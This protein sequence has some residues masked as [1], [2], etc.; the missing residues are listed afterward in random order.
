MK[1][2]GWLGS[3]GV[4]VLLACLAGGAVL[5]WDQTA[6]TK[7][8]V[9]RVAQAV[10]KALAARD[11]EEH[12]IQLPE[13]GGQFYLTVLTHENYQTRARDRELVA[14]FDSDPHLR[15]LKSQTQFNH[16]TPNQQIYATRLGGAV[17]V[18]EF[19]AV[20]LQESNGRVFFKAGARKLP[21]TPKELVKLIKD[22]C[23]RPKPPGP[24]PSPT[25]GPEPMPFIP[26]VGP[27]DEAP[28]GPAD[29]GSIAWLAALA[30]LLGGGLGVVNEHK[31][32]HGG[33]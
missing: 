26:D 3:I 23:P 16:Y 18:T 8:E 25:P 5:Q 27:P 6:D 13:D 7:S 28:L 31:K 22:C 4:P 15:A 2:F 14:W 32:T 10:D 20:V 24:S 17:P 1:S 12:V 9:N 21:S 30:A 33:L 19:P 29:D 11:I